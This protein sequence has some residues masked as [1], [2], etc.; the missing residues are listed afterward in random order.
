M[1]VIRTTRTPGPLITLAIVALLALPPPVTASFEEDLE[2]A[3]SLANEKHYGEAR[4]ALDPLLARDSLHP[5]T[6]LLD[7]ILHAHEGRVGEAIEIFDRLRRDH[8]DMP[9]PWNNLA[10]LLASQGRLDE[11]RETL[12]AA[13]GL[14]PSA[15]GYANLGDV[16]AS[17]A[18]RAYLRSREFGGDGG[19]IP[20]LGESKTVALSVPG[21][22][23][24]IARTEP[25]P[26]EGGIAPMPAASSAA[27]PTRR[28]ACLRSGAFEERSAIADTRSWLESRG[29]Q[30]LEVH[31]EEVR[32]VSTHQ[33][34]LPPLKDRSM[35]E[36]SVRK[37]RARGVRDVAVIRGGPLANGISFG[38][39]GVME[40]MRRRV[41]ALERLG[42][43]ALS[44]DNATTVHRYSVEART[45]EDPDGLFAAWAQ[46]F[47][48]HSLERV[49][50]G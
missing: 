22:P 8:P 19:A 42:Y 7:G 12:L 45:E 37:I 33:V 30:V 34:Y 13:L 29:A 5:R 48:E 50:C 44:R 49:D 11:A 39:F 28:P 41:A 24:A 32:R 18:Q 47:P 14:Q 27:S 38:V 6:R 40:N 36:E 26:A 46:R 21:D 1:G 3:I 23:S 10:V 35:A 16:Y 15:I 9:E 25:P 2:R 4:E 17:L 43:P 31:R 20:G